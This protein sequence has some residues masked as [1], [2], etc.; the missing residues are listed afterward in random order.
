MVANGGAPGEEMVGVPCSSCPDNNPSTLVY[1]MVYLMA[2]D[3]KDMLSISYLRWLTLLPIYLS[4][5]A[6][7]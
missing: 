5:K 7:T 3:T 2:T 6:Q 4:T 1:L